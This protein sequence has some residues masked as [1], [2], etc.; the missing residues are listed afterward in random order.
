MYNYI[1]ATRYAMSEHDE[2][3]RSIR[4]FVC[5]TRYRVTGDLSARVG[6]VFGRDVHGSPTGV[7]TLFRFRRKTDDET[8]CRKRF[9]FDGVY[10]EQ[11]VL[12]ICRTTDRCVTDDDR[13]RLKTCPKNT[14]SAVVRT[15]RYTA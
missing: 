8:L 9:R 12:D 1:N 5:I 2:T 14:N 11:Y 3:L 4:I 15:C 13:D 7:T 10:C 6:R